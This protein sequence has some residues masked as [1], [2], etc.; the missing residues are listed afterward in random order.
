MGPVNRTRDR[1]NSS[2]RSSENNLDAG[3]IKYSVIDG[4]GS[5]MLGLG[6]YGK[7]GANGNAFHSLL[8]NPSVVIALLVVG[9]IVMA[10]G[11]FNML[12]LMKEKAKRMPLDN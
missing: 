9:A 2:E 10:W 3:I 5:V 8:D 4:V 7:Y 12:S 6:L 11:G 1:D